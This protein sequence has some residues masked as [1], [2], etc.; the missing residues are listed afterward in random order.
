MTRFFSFKSRITSWDNLILRGGVARRGSIFAGP[1]YQRSNAMRLTWEF[2]EA[3]TDEIIRLA[4]VYGK[5]GNSWRK[6]VINGDL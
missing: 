3:S 6:A 5:N 4:W 2:K 1:S